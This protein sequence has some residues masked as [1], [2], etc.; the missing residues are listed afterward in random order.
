MGVSTGLLGRCS[1]ILTY[2][3]AKLFITH[4]W[5]IKT[6]V[7]SC[8]C[9]NRTWSR[10][11]GAARSHFNTRLM[12]YAVFR[13]LRVMKKNN[14]LIRPQTPKSQKTDVESCIISPAKVN[15]EGYRGEWGTR[16]LQTPAEDEEGWTGDGCGITA[17]P[18]RLYLVLFWWVLVI[19]TDSITRHFR[20]SARIKYCHLHELCVLIV[21]RAMWSLFKPH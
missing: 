17:D 18:N 8:C 3:C 11:F 16:R 10:A 7:A 20:Q 14:V 15:T 2:K 12:T 6:Q 13:P 21:M 9:Y 5:T 1:Q 4:D 19:T